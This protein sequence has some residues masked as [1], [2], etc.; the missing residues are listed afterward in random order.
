MRDRLYVFLLCATCFIGGNVWSQHSQDTK[1]V[2]D[3]SELES[4]RH[5]SGRSYLPFLNV[6]S[7]HC[8]VYSLDA[9][10]KDGQQPHT[11]DEVYYVESGKAK[12]QIE[13][14][15]FDLKA[16]SVVFVPAQAKHHFHSITDDLKTLVFFSKGPTGNHSE[17]KPS[18]RKQS[19]SESEPD[20]L[21]SSISGSELFSANMDTGPSPGLFD[22]DQF[23]YVAGD[24]NRLGY[25]PRSAMEGLTFV[26]QGGVISGFLNF[27]KKTKQVLLY[28]AKETVGFAPKPD[29]AGT[30]SF[31]LRLDPDKDLGEGYCDPLQIAGRKWDDAA[32]WVDF[33]QGKPRS[34]RLGIFSDKGH[35]NPENKKWDEIPD[36]KKPVVT[37]KN[38]PFRSEQWTHVA[39]TFR[40]INSTDGK[41]GV[42]RLYLNGELAGSIERDFKFTWNQDDPLA[43]VMIGLNYIGGFDEFKIYDR[44]LSSAEIAKV[45]EYYLEK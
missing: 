36:D 2:F 25:E 19:S 15:D 38:P 39:I 29:W 43:A 32:I 14:E 26:K 6:D 44:E 1:R 4:K 3:F 17:M 45:N 21:P 40:G 33:D 31:F 28:K 37:I 5:E 41:P 42:A 8:G 22:K 34:F 10:S 35:W 13:G 16:G 18:D 30:I 24:I 27:E 12:I 23:S 20:E 7:L 9:G 11:Q